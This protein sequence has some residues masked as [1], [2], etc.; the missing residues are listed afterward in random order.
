MRRYPSISRQRIARPYSGKLTSCNPVSGQFPSSCTAQDLFQ[1]R[2]LPIRPCRIR[3]ASGNATT[4][5]F[6][7][8]TLGLNASTTGNRIAWAC[9]TRRNLGCCSLPHTSGSWACAQSTWPG[10]LPWRRGHDVPVPVQEFPSSLSM[11]RWK[12]WGKDLGFGAASWAIHCDWDSGKSLR[13][14]SA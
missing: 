6:A 2:H 3:D 9:R 14:L 13:A 8:R 11:T 4:T 10:N 12:A 5:R 1:S 7:S